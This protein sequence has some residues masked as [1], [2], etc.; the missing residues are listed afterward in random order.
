MIKA[1]RARKRAKM[2]Q[3]WRHRGTQERMQRFVAGEDARRRDGVSP[4]ALEER[5]C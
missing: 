2:Q 4:A 3:N 1:V 5:P